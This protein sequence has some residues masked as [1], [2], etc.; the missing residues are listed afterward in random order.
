MASAGSISRDHAIV[1]VDTSCNVFIMDL[2]TSNGTKVN[3][4]AINP[5]LPQ[6]ITS[7][8]KI[9][10]GA[11]SRNYFFSIDSQAY[12]R[13]REAVYSKIA[14]FESGGDST[15]D[16]TVFVGGLP[17]EATERHIRDF[18]ETCGVISKISIPLDKTTGLKRGIAFV[19]FE[20]SSGFLQG[21]SRDRDLLLDKE[22]KVNLFQ[23]WMCHCHNAFMC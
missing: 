2:H 21:M 6:L 3:D 5:F 16:L 17:M 14:N 23:L 18:F 4:K 15:S 8:S 22:I 20:T 19:T 9:T 1:F 10:L 12:E 13:R 7:R 11:S